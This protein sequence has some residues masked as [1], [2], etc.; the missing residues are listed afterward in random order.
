MLRV[1]LPGALGVFLPLS[2]LAEWS[3]LHSS[4]AADGHGMAPNTGMG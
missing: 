4:S 3:I 2:P 1:T